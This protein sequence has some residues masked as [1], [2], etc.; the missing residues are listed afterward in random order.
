MENHHF[1]VLM[2]KPAMTMAMF[3]SYVTNHQRVRFSPYTNHAVYPSRNP[4]PHLQGIVGTIK[5]TVPTG[6]VQLTAWIWPKPMGDGNGR[7]MRPWHSHRGSPHISGLDSG[8]LQVGFDL[9]RRCTRPRSATRTV[10]PCAPSLH[11]R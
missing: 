4:K 1:Q 7:D 9:V 3:N 11:E 10:S 5:V 6:V 8:F 2:G